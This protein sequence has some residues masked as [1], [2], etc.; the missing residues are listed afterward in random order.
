MIGSGRHG[1]AR[2]WARPH[3]RARVLLIAVVAVLAL[4]LEAGGAGALAPA[5]P[6]STPTVTISGTALDS[7]AR[8]L[9]GW[10]VDFEDS[11]GHVFTSTDTDLPGTYS[12]SVPVTATRVVLSDPS[13]SI[14]GK[15]MQADG[16]VLT[17]PRTLN[18]TLPVVDV[19]FLVRD[20]SRHRLADIATGLTVGTHKAVPVPPLFPGATN[21]V[22]SQSVSQNYRFTDSSGLTSFTLLDESTYKLTLAAL[23][24]GLVHFQSNSVS[25]VP[26]A[27]R[28]LGV[29][30]AP[31]PTVTPGDADVIPTPGGSTVAQVP[32]TLS[33]PSNQ[34]LR[35]D[36]QTVANPGTAPTTDYVAAH[37]FVFLSAG[38]TAGT[39]PITVLRNST[40][41]TETVDVQLIV[42]SGLVLA[43]D[44]G[45]VDIE[46]LPT[47]AP[48]TA[49]VTAPT[50]GTVVVQVPVTLSQASTH[51][52]T[53]SWTTE[54]LTD[55]SRPT[56]APT[57]DYLPASG[58]VSFA[59]GQTSAT[60][61]ITVTGDSL[62]VVEYLV[63]AFTNPTNAAIGG[64][65]GL[66][67]AFIDPP[68]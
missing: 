67:I 18:L 6:A 48:G 55:G 27:D 45:H 38:Q 54:F 53:A 30:L 34:A 10:E 36:W 68:A 52:V 21:S 62:G 2:G 57:T 60:V 56:Q 20:P 39:I 49:T 22:G 41:T 47:I 65:W 50:S 51:T 66:G 25:W 44:T 4:G 17:G 16:L 64:F 40:G 59:P 58:T 33:A 37:G 14:T 19:T 8:A 1:S 24:S 11:T 3:L 31:W 5:Q 23:P 63:L 13:D 42:S 26:T 43:S 7:K 32:F 61:P 12:A 28:A 35:L 46:P 15:R 9:A 29:L